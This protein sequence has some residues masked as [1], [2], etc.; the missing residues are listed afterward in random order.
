MIK[1]ELKEVAQTLNKI[2]KASMKPVITIKGYKATRK[3]F[4]STL[5]ENN[6]RKLRS[7]V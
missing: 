4:M 3:Y 1:H 7:A 2:S 6:R 5:K